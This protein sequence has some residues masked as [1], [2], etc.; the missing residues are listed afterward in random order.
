MRNKRFLYTKYMGK[1]LWDKIFIERLHCKRKEVTEILGRKI[2]TDQEANDIIVEYI[3]K[4][5]PFALLRPGNSEFAQVY[6]WDEHVLWGSARFRK[7]K[8]FE[9]IDGPR[10]DEFAKR[11][12]ETFQKD[13]ADA[14]IFAFFSENAPMENY[15]VDMYAN[16]KH[17]ILLPQIESFWLENAWIK[18]LEGKR[19]LIISPF[20]ETMR[21][22]YEK[23]DKI[24]QGL[25]ILPD[26]DLKF[27]KSVWYMGARDNGGFESWFDALEYL[28]NQACQEDFDIALLG[29]GGFSTFLA[30]RFK[31]DGK[32]AIQYG[33]ALQLLFGIR[34]SRWDD[35]ELYKKYYNEY[36]VR[37]PQ[38]EAPA[39]ANDLDGRCYW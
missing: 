19:V 15:L 9:S 33:G 24:W 5:E 26:M 30:A 31:R 7:H 25:D 6:Y 2:P 18:Q 36:W 8:Q 12:S 39:R 32:Q 38:N 34:G 21:T 11:W 1:R 22:Q 27:V 10:G 13:L 37:P 29:C 4:G 35:M 20:V 3:K 17:I 16:P 14:D 23:R 28:Y